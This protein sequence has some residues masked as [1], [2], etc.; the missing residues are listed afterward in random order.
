[1]RKYLTIGAGRSLRALLWKYS[2]L[3]N[4]SASL[5]YGGGPSSSI[6]LGGISHHILRPTNSHVQRPGETESCIAPQRIHATSHNLTSTP[7]QSPLPAQRRVSGV[8]VPIAS[9]IRNSNLRNTIPDE[10]QR[11]NSCYQNR[12]VR[13]PL[14]NRRSLYE[15]GCPNQIETREL[16]NRIHRNDQMPVDAGQTQKRYRYEMTNYQNLWFLYY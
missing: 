6:K 7:R 13:S 9:P 14:P 12:D 1:M 10:R 8:T 3:L 15:V 2:L 11:P 5:V 4:P 16:Q